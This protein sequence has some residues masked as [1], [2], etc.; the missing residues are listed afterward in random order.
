MIVRITHSFVSHVACLMSL[1]SYNFYKKYDRLDGHRKTF[2][3]F[4]MNAVNI[5]EMWMHWFFYFAFFPDVCIKCVKLWDRRRK[6]SCSARSEFGAARNPCFHVAS[7]KRNMTKKSNHITRSVRHRI[8]GETR[9]RSGGTV[10]NDG[11]S[12]SVLSSAEMEAC[13]TFR[14]LQRCTFLRVASR[15]PHSVGRFAPI[16]CQCFHRRATE[17]VK[18]YTQVE[19]LASLRF[20]QTPLYSFVAHLDDVFPL[21]VTIR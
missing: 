16:N 17:S 19:R 21:C 3:C 7:S 4:Y 2:F 18:F 9:V 20:A 6:I 8:T 11:A 10:W 12:K 14:K 1:I 13:N 5:S 15:T